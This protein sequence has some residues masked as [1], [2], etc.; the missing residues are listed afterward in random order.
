MAHTCFGEYCIFTPG[1]PWNC[2]NWVNKEEADK[3]SAQEIK[4]AQPPVKRWLK[5][6]YKEIT[7]SQEY[8]NFIEELSKVNA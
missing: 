5:W 4:A 1:D 8:R 6:Q 7:S 3:R 2:L